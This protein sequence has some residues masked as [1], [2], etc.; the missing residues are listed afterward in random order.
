MKVKTL[1]ERRNPKRKNRLQKKLHCGLY[2]DRT[3][4]V[5][6]PWKWP[7]S[8][9]GD[10]WSEVYDRQDKIFDAFENYKS[11]WIGTMSS[12][13]KGMEVLFTF[14]SG[15]MAHSEWTK[16][17]QDCID[18][19]KEVTGQDAYLLVND[20]LFKDSWYDF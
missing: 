7:D 3:F 15:S 20:F 9:R 2:E 11:V 1:E 14:A 12:E 18:K 8:A 4:E 16:V 5:V 19:I 6:I 13:K 10:D 17:A